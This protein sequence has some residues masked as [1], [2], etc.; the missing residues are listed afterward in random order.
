MSGNDSAQWHNREA[1]MRGSFILAT[2]A[3]SQIRLLLA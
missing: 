1:L 2:F 3:F